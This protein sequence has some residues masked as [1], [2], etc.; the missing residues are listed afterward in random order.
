MNNTQFITAYCSISSGKVIA[1]NAEIFT[2]D[3]DVKQAD[4]F[5]SVY[6]NFE[7]NYPKFY[8]M[9]YLCKLAF[10]TSDILLK[11]NPLKEKYNGENIAIIISNSSS[12]LET[13][14]EHQS[15]ISDKN[16]FFPSPAVFVYTLPNILIGEIAIRNNIKGENSL[17]IFENFQPKFMYQYIDLLFN[18]SATDC[19]IAGY[20]DFYEDNYKALLYTVEKIPGILDITHTEQNLNQLFNK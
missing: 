4:F 10:I 5:K 2:S 18:S 14:T 13:D 20:V 1:N 8:K 6:K 3:N 19:C 12:S 15:T 7:M 17:F 16:N 11:Y 9:D